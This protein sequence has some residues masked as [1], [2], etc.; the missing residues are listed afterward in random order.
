[1]GHPRQRRLFA[2]AKQ[3]SAAPKK[4]A[5]AFYSLPR[6]EF[7]LA[8]ATEQVDDLSKLV[9]NRSV[10]ADDRFTLEIPDNRMADAGIDKGDYAVVKQQGGY[11]D[12]DIIAARLGERVFVRRFFTAAQRIR[13]ECTTPNRQSMILD[14]DTPGF[15]I[16]GCVVQ[17]IKEF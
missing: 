6:G 14:L 1:M 16:L 3:Q 9:I 17:V 4:P 11:H 8:G 10:Q 12:G 5:E 2:P 15:S 7:L 13:L